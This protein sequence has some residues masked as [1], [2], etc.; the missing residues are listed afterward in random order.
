MKRAS[1]A[2][3]AQAAMHPVELELEPG[4]PPSRK[5]PAHVSLYLDPRVIRKIKMLAIELDCRPH[6]LLIEAVNLMLH[7]RGQPTT[8]ELTGKKPKSIAR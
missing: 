7:R 4:S 2:A 3:I 8:A 5:F 6:D 1:L